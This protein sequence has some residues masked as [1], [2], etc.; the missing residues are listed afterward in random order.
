MIGQA[1]S[2]RDDHQVL[3]LALHG[4]PVP[5]PDVPRAYHPPELQLQ[6]V[7][8][9]VE[10]VDRKARWQDWRWAFGEEKG[11]REQARLY[12]EILTRLRRSADFASQKAAA[13][14]AW[15]DLQ[16]A[17][18]P[19]N[20][21]VVI[22]AYSAGATIVFR[23]LAQLETE[24]TERVRKVKKIICVAGLYEFRS[25]D[26]APGQIYLPGRE[27]PITVM[28]PPIKP[29]DICRAV[30]PG[31]LL[32]LLGEHDTTADPHFNSFDVP[33]CAHIE[34]YVIEGVDHW[35][36]LTDRSNQNN[37]APDHILRAIT[38]LN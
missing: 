28:E 37:N 27:D 3:V 7:R 30:S 35:S 8:A 25:G 31:Q 19:D 32:A 36:I 17:D 1:T 33:E 6:P 26:L 9:D 38:Q 34:C 2:T 29:R 14:R 23:W 18:L 15:F 21:K 22:L 16:T 4:L 11:E 13:F 20:Y 24:D 10:A 5:V 12:S